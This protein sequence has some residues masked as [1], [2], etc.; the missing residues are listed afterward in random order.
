MYELMILTFLMRGPMHGYLI[1]KIINDITGPFTKVSNG[2]LYPL[3]AKLEAEGLIVAAEPT[4]EHPHERRHHAFQITEAGQQRFHQLM[5][6]TTSNPGDYH[7][8]FWVKVQFFEFLHPAEQ[9]YL[10]DHYINF[11]QTHIFHLT[12]EMSDLAREA[13]EKGFL[14]PHQLEITLATMQHLQDRWRLER[15][16]AKDWR[17]RYVAREALPEQRQDNRN[18]NRN[19]HQNDNQNDHNHQYNHSHHQTNEV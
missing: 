10:V 4:A 19:D 2:R 16:A 13:P 12:G 11:C 3:L 7:N 5:M 6:D 17:E 8:L 1:A 9:L 14:T 18:E 15:A